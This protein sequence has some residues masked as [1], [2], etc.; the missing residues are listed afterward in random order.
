ME[1]F[2]A[3]PMLFVWFSYVRFTWLLFLSLSFLH[4]ESTVEIQRYI[5]RISQQN[6]W[7]AKRDVQ[8]GR[9]RDGTFSASHECSNRLRTFARP[10]GEYE[11]NY[12]HTLG[13]GNAVLTSC[14]TRKL[15]WFVLLCSN[16]DISDT[17]VQQ[18][19]VL[20]RPKNSDNST[21]FNY[22]GNSKISGVENSQ[23]FCL[24]WS[25]EL[26]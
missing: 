25:R 15:S 12:S 11:A 21:F 9:V 2:C 14:G 26:L 7:K 16:T 24:S 13:S 4:F 23:R 5:E 10:A 18:C 8:L 19:R 22:I 3:E 1:T 20:I 6:N 17:H